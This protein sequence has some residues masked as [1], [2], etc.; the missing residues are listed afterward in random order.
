MQPQILRNKTWKSG[1]FAMRSTLLTLVSL[2]ALFLGFSSVANA[3]KP[4]TMT[5]ARM[6]SDSR[7]RKPGIVKLVKA[8]WGTLFDPNSKQQVSKDEKES[9]AR[10]KETRKGKSLKN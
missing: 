4:F 5:S 8:F 9:S 1:L 3:S 2:L 6:S 10:K 7:S